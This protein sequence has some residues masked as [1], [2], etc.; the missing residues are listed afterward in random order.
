M[1]RFRQTISAI[2]ITGGAL[3]FSCPAA[4][5]ET[6]QVYN[7]SQPIAD[8]TEVLNRKVNETLTEIVE[9]WQKG[10]DERVFV[11]SVYSKLG[12]HHWVDKLER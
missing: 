11:N 6:D 7:R 1:A 2:A 4:A 9:T 12:G 3:A 10:E 5:Y 8:S